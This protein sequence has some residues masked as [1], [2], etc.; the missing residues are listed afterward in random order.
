MSE[1]TAN[2]DD[3]TFQRFFVVIIVVRQHKW[4]SW[5]TET[6]LDNIG[7]LLK[8]NYDFRN[9]TLFD[10]ACTFPRI[11][12]KNECPHCILRPK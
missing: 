8:G 6:Y 10:L 7:V 9:L 2:A 1:K 4:H 3:G 5:N 11:K 12:Y